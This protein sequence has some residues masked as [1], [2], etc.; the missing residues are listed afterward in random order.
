MKP[1]RCVSIPMCKPQQVEACGHS[2]SKRK[3]SGRSVCET[4]RP[5]DCPH[6]L[7]E[8]LPC[9]FG[10]AV[11]VNADIVVFPCSRCKKPTKEESK[12]HSATFAQMAEQMAKDG[13]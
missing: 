8:G 10:A 1:D 7:C 9:L 11:N 5:I 6:L 12:K 3:W 2:L 4:L 13:R